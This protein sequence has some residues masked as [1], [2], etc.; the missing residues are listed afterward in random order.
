MGFWLPTIIADMGVKGTFEIGV[1][2]AIPYAVA[3][4]GMVLVGRSS[5]RRNERRWHF[6]VSAACG[7]VGLILSVLF[8]QQH[9]VSLAALT[10]A[11]FGILASAPLFWTFPTSF[12]Q[13][14]AAAAGIAIINSC[15][16][17]AGFAIPFVVG[18]IK[19]AT[20]ST[21]AGMYLI[22][23]LLIGGGALGLAARFSRRT[24]ARA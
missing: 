22:A 16:N 18:W 12:L 2:T 8:A 14:A 17:L 24:T 11:T 23:A 10:L 1:L 19:D 7:G 21:G 6:A 3:A 9:A 15:G 20:N 4:V 5:D 13:G